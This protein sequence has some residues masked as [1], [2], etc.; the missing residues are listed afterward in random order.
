V[1]GEPSV[2]CFC[3]VGLNTARG[4]GERTEDACSTKPQDTL[5]ATACSETTSC[6]VGVT[7]HERVP[8]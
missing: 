5:S 1:S 7:V 6:D 2:S 4:N 3:H 8:T